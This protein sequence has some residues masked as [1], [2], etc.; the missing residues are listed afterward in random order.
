MQVGLLKLNAGIGRAVQQGANLERRNGE[1]RADQIDARDE[2]LA[3]MLRVRAERGG[4]VVALLEVAPE[5]IHLYGCAAVRRTDEDDV[6]QVTG[7]VELMARVR[8]NV[9][10]GAVV[11]LVGPFGAGKS[12]QAESWFARAAAYRDTEGAPLPMWFHASALAATTV[13]QA[14][15]A[16]LHDHDVD[17]NVAIVIDGLDEVDP[18]VASQ[19]AK[20]TRVLIATHSASSAIMAIRPGVLPCDDTDMLCRGPR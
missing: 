9:P 17:F 6:V 16:R 7:L 1:L 8:P 11:T 14:V 15:R 20:Q 13:D 2:L 3:R 18:D 5:Q 4:S 10:A 19:V 12:E